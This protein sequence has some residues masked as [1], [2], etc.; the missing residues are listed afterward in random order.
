MIELKALNNV[1]EAI[2]HL[3]GT[4]D[5]RPIGVMFYD[6]MITVAPRTRFKLPARGGPARFWNCHITCTP[7]HTARL[8]RHTAMC[9]VVEPK[10]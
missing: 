5:L 6:C 2:V 3:S 1:R 4:V 7:Q 9:Y 10:P 8:R